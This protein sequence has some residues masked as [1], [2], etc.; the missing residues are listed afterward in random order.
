MWVRL[1]R[2]GD[3]EIATGLDAVEESAGQ[4]GRALDALNA[5]ARTEGRSGSAERERAARLQGLGRRTAEVAH[6]FNNLL[7]GIV[8]CADLA[9]DHLGSET[10]ARPHVEDLKAAALRGMKLTGKLLDTSRA[11]E[12]PPERADIGAALS[13]CEPVLRGLLGD[14][15]AL[16]VR[17]PTRPV[18]VAIPPVEIEQI[19]LNLAMNARRA[20]AERG[21]FTIE[22]SPTEAREGDSVPSI[23]PHRYVMLKVTDDGAGMDEATRERAFEPFFSGSRGGGFGLGLAT[24]RAIIAQRGGHIDLQSEVGRGTSIRML[25]PVADDLDSEPVSGLGTIPPPS[26]APASSPRSAARASRPTVLLVEDDDT[27]RRAMTTFL[28]RRG[29]Q[30]IAAA[31]GVLAARA[32]SGADVRLDV[33]VT[34]LGLEAT[35]GVRLASDL[36][37]LHRRAGVLYIS[38]RSEADPVVK[39]ALRAPRTAFL[40]KPFELDELVRQTG[41]L[42]SR[43]QTVSKLL[44]EPEGD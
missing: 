17:A 11:D 32:C 25:L 38:G 4:L 39:R 23:R 3:A 41:A 42:V 24:V 37:A 26:S 31:N 13:Q 14:R 22:A 12:P 8:G 43:K 44:G 10:A 2:D 40:R 9:L 34:D 1:L 16:A 5:T 21:H 35:T 27:S 28:E 15:V 6:D 20:I 36:R 33:I 19:L 30:V 7:L 29:F 18:A